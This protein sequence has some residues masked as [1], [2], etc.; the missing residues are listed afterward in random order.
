LDE[1]I[2]SE[3]LDQISLKDDLLLR[4]CRHQ[5]EGRLDGKFLVIYRFVLV[6]GGG[7]PPPILWGIVGE[8]TTFFIVVRCVFIIQK[9]GEELIRGEYLFGEFGGEERR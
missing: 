5:F 1:F 3:V 8:L 4:F 2:I 7:A 6:V 9:R